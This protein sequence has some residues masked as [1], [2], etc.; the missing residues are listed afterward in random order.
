MWAPA[1][2]GVTVRRVHLP[3]VIPAQA[4]TL[5]PAGALHGCAVAPMDECRGTDGVRSDERV[6][7][8]RAML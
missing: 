7:L 3:R 5:G 8:D 2:A 1:F 6:L 4:G